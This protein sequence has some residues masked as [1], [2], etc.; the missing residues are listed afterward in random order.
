MKYAG[1]MSLATV[2]LALALRCSLGPTAGTEVGNPTRRVAG[3]VVD[4]AGTGVAGAHVT[5]LPRDYNPVADSS[6]L[7]VTAVDGE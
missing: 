3:V 7:S 1:R 2:A 4:S 6:G 5:L